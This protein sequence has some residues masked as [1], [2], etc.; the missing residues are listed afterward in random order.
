M[1]HLFTY[2][3]FYKNYFV[4]FR[5]PLFFFTTIMVTN[6]NT[7]IHPDADK[8]PLYTVGCVIDQSLADNALKDSVDKVIGKIQPTDLS[9]QCMPS[10]GHI[11]PL[12]MARG[13]K[14][15][16]PMKVADVSVLQNTATINPYLP[17]KNIQYI[18]TLTRITYE[19][20]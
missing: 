12:S 3:N 4:T 14:L 5:K 1:I 19:Y 2:F 11:I 13:K 18:I 9:I 17:A 16:N 20:K 8:N 6:M 7:P 15:P 10:S